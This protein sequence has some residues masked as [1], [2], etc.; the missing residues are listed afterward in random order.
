MGVV[1]TAVKWAVNVAND[2]NYYYL[3]GGW[4]PYGYDCGHFVITAYEKAGL[5]LQ[6][7]GA[8]Y[9][10]DMRSAFLKCGFVDV[11]SSVNR[12]NGAGM[13]RGDVLIDADA[14]A[15]MVQADGGITVE[16][17]S[18]RYGI[19]C[20]KA[21]RNHPWD[22]VL[23]YP[24]SSS[25]S[26][27]VETSM[28][29]ENSYSADTKE[30]TVVWNNRVSEHLNKKLSSQTNIV[31]KAGELRLYVNGVEV[32]YIA[33]SLSWQNSIYELS[34]LMSFEVAKTD[35][36]FISNLVYVPVEGDIVSLFADEEVYRGIIKDMDDGD[37][38]KNSYNVVDLGWYCNKT[39]Q[40]FQFK[41]ISASTAIKNMCSD[42]GIP[43]DM[44]PEL[45]TVIDKIY[46][47]KTVS[48]IIK[49]ILSLCKGTYN[50]DFT[51]KGLRIYEVG[52]LIAKPEFIVAGNVRTGLSVD[53]MGNVS[54][55]KSIE[56]M[57]NSIKITAEKDS[58]YKEI[59]VKQNRDLIDSFGFLQ[60]IVKI[61]PETQNANEV[62][63]AE[64]EEFGKV[65]EKYSFEMIERYNSYTRAGECL[66]LNGTL[67]V[68]EST[69]HS[70]SNGFHHNALELL[71]R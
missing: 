36:K 42:L 69:S 6:A 30:P 10:G 57:R 65:E 17:L 4:G 44:L 23:R 21:Y 18:S 48:D 32:T 50:Y 9:T 2:D 26:S 51:P 3:W 28:Y 11:T 34:T 60:K 31:P 66:E 25:S 29:S 53:Y 37:E 62:A 45:G 61:D 12:G 20:N 55:S 64:L 22:Y 59:L 5:K 33:G 8:T 38:N 58:V 14:H 63:T 24:E 43:I 27:S 68:I 19:V 15:A 71:R 47:D 16:A 46:F 1:D 70:F 13:K 40:T 49:D 56:D 41:K 67:Y 39:E 35:A 7:A 52:T 54:H